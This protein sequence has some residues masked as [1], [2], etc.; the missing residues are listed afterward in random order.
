MKRP[1]E[2]TLGADLA[3]AEKIDGYFTSSIKV[4]TTLETRIACQLLHACRSLINGLEKVQPEK[5]DDSVLDI[6]QRDWEGVAKSINNILYILRLPT[7]AQK[8][9]SS[10]AEE[11]SECP[12]HTQPHCLVCASRQTIKALRI[13]IVSLA[14]SSVS[15][16][17]D[18]G[19][20]QSITTTLHAAAIDI[21]R[22]HSDMRSISD[23]D[24]SE[25]L[26]KDTAQD[27]GA[28]E[29][30]DLGSDK[31]QSKPANTSDSQQ[32]I[33]IALGA[34]SKLAEMLHIFARISG[35]R[36]VSARLQLT[37]S[38]SIPS[39]LA[40]GSSPARHRRWVSE[41]LEGDSSATTSAG[42]E[43][44]ISS[45]H[46]SAGGN[47]LQGALHARNR[48]DS[49]IQAVNPHSVYS[50][51]KSALSLR[52]SSQLQPQLSLQSQPGASLPST[53]DSNERSKQVRFQEIPS[54][55]PS[56]DQTHLDEL[57]Q[58]LPRFEAAIAELEFTHKDY[59]SSGN[60]DVYVR[61]IR[62]LMTAFVKLSRLSSTSGLVKHY[63]KAALAQFKTTT[64]AIR[65]LMPLTN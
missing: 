27:S 59:C 58:F 25:L 3:T 39:P 38:P 50:L 24:A 28:T 8:Q 23:K 43:D 12:A 32:T 54:A 63:D 2:S 45:R 19:S 33:Q 29:D 37:H 31:T 44:D 34:A 18:K 52:K 11:T 5:L 13:Y 1:P 40:A 61:A 36:W 49:R 55:E 7:H 65:L 53:S 15:S 14:S 51:R 30:E 41:E 60:K 62:G 4:P 22:I 17:T 21:S 20:L 46:S 16:I 48:S 56:I 64:Q 9:Y 35:Q 26:Q 42:L 47:H 6:C 10:P 57:V